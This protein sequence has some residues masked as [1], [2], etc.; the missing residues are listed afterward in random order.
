MDHC[1]K[2]PFCSDDERDD[3]EDQLCWEL[4]MEVFD[5]VHGTYPVA[6]HDVAQ[7]RVCG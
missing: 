7:R 6:N 4:S 5:E 3:V 2:D 1:A